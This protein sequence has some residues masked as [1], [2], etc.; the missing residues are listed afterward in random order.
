MVVQ[1]VKQCSDH[2]KIAFEVVVLKIGNRL[3]SLVWE[4]CIQQAALHKCQQ[5]NK[6]QRYETLRTYLTY[7][8]VSVLEIM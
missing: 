7:L 3:L 6:R 2:T 5:L 8:V 4:E 1:N